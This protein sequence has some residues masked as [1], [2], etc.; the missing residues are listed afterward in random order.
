MVK[1]HLHT[2]KRIQGTGTKQLCNFKETTS[3]WSLSREKKASVRYE[4]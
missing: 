2:L 3:Q 4:A 1:E